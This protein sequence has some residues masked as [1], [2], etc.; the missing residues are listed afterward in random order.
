MKDPND[1]Y[2]VENYSDKELFDILDIINPTDREL[3]AKILHM[4]WKYDNIGNDSGVKLTN[5]FKSI[6]DHFFDNTEEDTIENTKEEITLEGFDNIQI[7]EPDNKSKPQDNGNSDSRNIGYSF[8]IDYSKDTLNPLLKQT[9][10]RIISID[11]QYRDNKSSL[12]TDFTFDLSDPLKDV[13]NLK[14]YSI[15]IPYTWWTINANYGSNFFFLK[16]NSPGINDGNHDFKISIPVGN[17]TAPD[18]V[19]AVN[20][21]I[22][23]IINNPSYSDI[24]F[25]TTGISYDYPSSKATLTFDLTNNYTE[26]YYTF[27]FQNWSSPNDPSNNNS[28][29]PGFFGFNRQT[30]YQYRIY[31]IMNVLQL[32]S[33]QGAINDN[34]ASNYRLD[35]SNNFFTVIQYVGINPSTEYTN[36]AD[37]S[38]CVVKKTIIVRLSNLQ[39]GITYSRNQLYN[40]L[41][42]QLQSNPNFSSLSK[43]NRVDVDSSNQY[44]IGHGNSH[45]E[46]DVRLNRSTTDNS[47]NV[48]TAVIFPNDNTI[49]VGPGSAFVFETSQY[50][51]SDII[52]ET[53]AVKSS[54]TAYSIQSNP[55]IYLKCIKPNYNFDLDY[56]KVTDISF[57]D[58]KIQI[59]NDN[60][61]GYYLDE[62]IT[63]INNS[64]TNINNITINPTNTTGDF[65][66]NNIPA[67][68]N[69]QSLFDLKIDLTKTFT[70]KDYLMDLS[71]NGT[72]T[73]L[74]RILN[75]PTNN[76]VDASY[77][78]ID[79]SSNAVF[80]SSFQL[81]GIGYTID[82]SYLM[83]IRQK[84][85]SAKNDII[86]RIPPIIN[87]TYIDIG[88]LESDI[89]TAFVS[90]TDSDGY[91]LFK[92]TKLTLSVTG[93]TV[94]SN[95][96]I[97]VRKYITQND[98]QMIL[99]DP[100][101]STIP[102]YSTY[103]NTWTKSAASNHAYS[104][105]SLSS[106][107]KY[108]SACV[109]GGGIYYSNNYGENWTQSDSSNK[110]HSSIAISSTGQY[111]I[112]GV[113]GGRIYYSNNYGENW[114]V[115][116]NTSNH[117]Y[118]SVSMSSDGK[119]QSACV[120]GGRIYYSDDNGATWSNTADDRFYSSIS[121]SSSGQYQSACTYNTG[122]I[123]YSDTS[124]VSWTQS[125]AS[126]ANYNS[127]SVSSSG[128]YQSACVNGGGIYYSNNYGV[129]W[130]K[131]DASNA[132]YNSITVS[133]S[134]QYHSVCVNGGGIY[135]ST[136]YG[137]NWTKSPASYIAYTSISV[138]SDGKYQSACVNGGGIY[139][140]VLGVIR[141]WSLTDASNSWAY[142][143]KLPYSSYNLADPS[144]NISPNTYSEIVG[145]STLISQQIFLNNTNNKIY[146]QPLT[147]DNG[148]DG[149]YTPDSTNDIIITIPNG[150]YDTN[151]LL[152]T[153]NNLFETTIAKGSSFSIYTLGL[154]QYIKIRLNINKTYTSS[155]YK[156]VF[157]DPVSF[158]IS[159][160][161]CSSGLNVNRNTTWDA[162][163]GWILGFRNSTEYD[164]SSISRTN[165]NGKLVVQLTGDTVVS[166][167][168]YNYFMIILDD[169]N[170]SHLNDGLVTTTQR[171][172][173]IPLPSY[174]NRATYRADPAT[175]KLMTSIYDSNNGNYLTQ[176]QMY[177][178]QEVINNMSNTNKY[179][180]S[181]PFAKNVFALLPMKTSGLANNEIYVDYGGT[182][183]NQE[184][185]YFGPVNI[186]RMTV[187]LINDKGEVVDLNGANWSF[188]IICEQLYQQKK[189]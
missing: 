181:G 186:H 122:T 168:I 120:N 109:N 156:L 69:S 46:L 30:Y 21:S 68:I 95:L 169:Y 9:V 26:P 118:S 85:S 89:N 114:T 121:V 55:Y 189:T 44:I 75:I 63:A 54:Q 179:Y 117:S 4:I 164:L 159:I 148:G 24:S 176:K 82:T 139:Y 128:Q 145:V 163:L 7:T 166:I 33:S 127:I 167:N 158:V 125:D 132:N 188:S 170:Q 59:A 147:I 142:N 77:I 87:K 173:N 110:N 42:I 112:S 111:Q 65:R 116:S 49:W 175:G 11:S 154:N 108:Q 103:G 60:G 86:H 73:A 51:L 36:P 180:S 172:N 37:I 161:R 144:Y 80:D 141:P 105:I 41:N 97:S 40:E 12:T 58:Y 8:P 1:I 157:Y 2:N 20:T 123:Y 171:E 72:K 177:A 88:L 143:L 149:V 62:Y 43:I 119:Y 174:T 31:S 183:Q 83:I 129:N 19:T 15:Q 39:T 100:S 93:S 126:N 67:S 178:A 32:T 18:L 6:Y 45:Y 136:N 27:S 76:P 3:E 66:L 138:S 150:F 71:Y 165:V 50:E 124:G 182:L 25:G 137:A 134:G 133:S 107:G 78:N 90:Y 17:Y 131:S 13:V 79:L 52:S 92:N 61:T 153:I 160:A 47:I 185:T 57:N 56:T 162:T 184:R 14:L 64:F 104:S 155:D 106:T 16:G 187:K 152:F 115:N 99:V 81:T 74:S 151:T 96:N 113:N 38:N 94:N 130:N 70:E 35:T 140:S 29:I 91:P 34:Q 135:I 5:F 53:S 23:S 146:L 48:K 22:T 10:K 102:D 98:Y 101:S 84:S 28:T